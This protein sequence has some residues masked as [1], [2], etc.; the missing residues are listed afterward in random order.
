MAAMMSCLRVL[1]AGCALLT[2][3]VSAG[4]GDDSLDGTG[5]AGGTGPFPD[6]EPL[7]ALSDAPLTTDQRIVPTTEPTTTALNPRLPEDMEQI[8]A[9][10]FGD[11]TLGAGEPVVAR[12]LDGS[13]AL[14][15]GP[16]ATMLFRFVHLADTQLAD[17]ESPARL[18]N[19]D[20]PVGSA[21]SSAFRPHEGHECRILNAAVRTINKVHEEIP[22]DFVIL[23]GD[24]AD[25]AQTNEVD[26][27]LSVLGGS[28]RVDC[29][30]GADDDP[31]PGP[32]N[33][34]KDPFY[35]DGLAM[36]FLW[37]NGNHDVLQQGNFTIA[38][39]EDEYLSDYA[40]T[41]TRDWSQPGG[42]VHIGDIVADERRKPLTGSELMAMVRAHGD[43]HGIPESAVAS[44]RASYTYDVEGT[45]V[46][47]IV[48]DTS[49][50]DTGSA[51]GLIRQ[52]HL[53]DFL[54][55]AMDAAV[56]DGKY[57]I[58]SSHHSSTKLTDGGGFGGE[59]QPDAILADAFRDFVGG[60][61]NVIMHLAGHTHRHSAVR[62]EPTTGFDYWEV[63]TA[64]LADWPHQMRVIEIW[65]LDNGHTSIRTIAL[66]YS[67]EHDAV[68]A[69][70][71][72]R[73][74]ADFTSGWEG[75]GSGEVSD[76][77]VELYVPQP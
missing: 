25:N 40:A 31:Q 52:S 33:D 29:D 66:D 70:G 74:I 54:E 65:D 43:G 42:P 1:V 11:F 76:R 61:N 22:I 20:A 5:G 37:V 4:C 15:P 18:V 68:A 59:E 49:A 16:N 21:T 64:A 7:P 28:A 62:I 24:N 12:T 55:P 47:F 27:V 36:P 67:T 34:P 10:G 72:A 35:A 19:A 48:I 39:R 71:R 57:V 6:P 9:D 8:L 38:G 44:G 32:E 13:D 2:I 63:E 50:T 46:R 45:P 73:G 17:D 58:L 26:W 30:S 56:A 60:Y 69:D 41:G 3:P 77:N 23:G 75:D 53:D 51:D 14:P